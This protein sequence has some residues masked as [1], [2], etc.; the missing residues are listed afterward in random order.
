MYLFKKKNQ[1]FSIEK[2]IF[3]NLP[4]PHLQNIILAKST[5]FQKVVT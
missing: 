1:L 4:T 5:T 3:E 2:K